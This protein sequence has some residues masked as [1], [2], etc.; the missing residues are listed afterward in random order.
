MLPTPLK[1]DDDEADRYLRFLSE[2]PTPAHAVVAVCNRLR[3]AGFSER[4]ADEDWPVEPGA[5]LLVV[6][7]DGRSVVALR[8]GAEAP[9]RSGFLIWGAHTDSP[10]LRLRLN[11]VRREAGV[12][13][14]LTQVHGGI[15]RRAWLDR[16][17]L[18][19]GAL[20]RVLRDG[21]GAPRFHPGS[22][23]PLIQRQLVALDRPLAI[24]PDLAIHLDR[25]KNEQ[26]AINPETALNAVFGCHDAIEDAVAALSLQLG[27]PLDEVDGFDL[28]LTPWQPPTRVGLAGDLLAGPRH[29]DLAMVYAGTA[30]LLAAAAQ[31]SGA[32]A[33]AVACFF[34]A[35][36]TGSTTASGAS[37]AFLRDLLLRVARAHPERGQAAPT[38]ALG[39]SLVLSGD[40]AHALHPNFQDKHDRAHAPLI[41]Q[42]L[43]V[44]VN[45]NDRYASTGAT[46]AA[47]RALCEA[48]EVPLQAY[49]HR[50]DMA[51]GTTIGPLTAARL[52]APTVD[53]GAPMWSMHSTVETMGARDLE[54]AVRLAGCFF[55]GGR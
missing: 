12:A 28:H 23:Q 29:D 48:A 1:T 10:D 22:G 42:G 51:C 30:G 41:N 2:S 46:T 3:S 27:L 5:Q 25:D 20:F 37:S 6:A 45:T 13:Q 43:V 18:L 15:I 32:G 38:L 33:T 50:Q 24:I 8:I 36:E 44:K 52:G 35:E 54:H 47:F 14:L 4:A 31:P 11:P 21:A 19:A 7:P 40:M 39:R 53:F 55:R 34:D 16:P 49:V 17:L 26:G 9:T